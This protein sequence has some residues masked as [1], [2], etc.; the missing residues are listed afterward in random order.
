MI[1]PSKSKEGQ[2]VDNHTPSRYGN[3][4][5]SKNGDSLVEGTDVG[6]TEEVQKKLE[7]RTPVQEH[8][9]QLGI[10]DT[11]FVSDDASPGHR[12]SLV[13]KEGGGAAKRTSVVEG[14][15]AK[16]I[17]LGEEE[18]E[19][20][21]KRSSLV[22]GEEGGATVSKSLSRIVIPLLKQ[23]SVNVAIVE[24]CLD[25]ATVWGGAGRRR[26]WCHHHTIP[27]PILQDC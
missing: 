20:G 25:V 22:L 27:Y 7:L 24:W 2:P 21:S 23:V 6:E 3:Q 19:G 12:S 14:G 11:A 5:G 16:R 17:A 15:A 10:D 13:S 9:P 18:E 4:N 26:A 8:V 1:R